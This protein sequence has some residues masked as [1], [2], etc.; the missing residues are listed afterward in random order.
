MAEILTGQITTAPGHEHT[1][2]WGTMCD[3]HPE[4]RAHYRVQGETDALSAKLTDMCE[5]CYQRHQMQEPD[6]EVEEC[7]WCTTPSTNL[8]DYRDLKEGLLGD[9]YRVCPKCIHEDQHNIIDEVPSEKM[10]FNVR[11]ADEDNDDDTVFLNEDN[12]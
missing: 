8:A 6:K 11:N 3:N 2:P 12:G 1:V 9:I 7:E 4:D 10:G 5:F